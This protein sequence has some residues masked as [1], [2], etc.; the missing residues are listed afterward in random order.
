MSYNTAMFRCSPLRVPPPSR[1]SSGRQPFMNLQ[2]Q[3]RVSSGIVETTPL[4]NNSY[5]WMHPRGAPATGDA[6]VR[7]DHHTPRLQ[8]NGLP[9]DV[10]WYGSGSAWISPPEYSQQ[11]SAHNDSVAS[12]HQVSQG[13][14]HIPPGVSSSSYSQEIDIA[15]STKPHSGTPMDLSTGRGQ[16]ASFGPINNAAGNVTIMSSSSRGGSIAGES[17][18]SY[19]QD[20]MISKPHMIG[21]LTNPGYKNILDESGDKNEV[22]S[23]QQVYSSPPQGVVISRPYPMGE[24]TPI[25]FSVG[26]LVES[27][28]AG[29]KKAS[30]VG[31][32]STTKPRT[33]TTSK[34][35][36]A[37]KLERKKALARVSSA[38]LRERIVM[39]QNMPE[40][41]RTEQ[42]KLELQAFQDRK[43]KKNRRSKERRAEESA[44]VERILAIPEE[45]RS[46][47]EK[48]YVERVTAAKLK[49][50]LQNR[51][52]RERLKQA[53]AAQDKAEMRRILAKPEVEWTKSEKNFLTK[54]KDTVQQT[55]IEELEVQTPVA[56]V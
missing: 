51:Q 21:D 5:C 15:M 16:S 9:M 30:K 24:A 11:V 43:G 19:T 50:N 13:D 12:R 2:Q 49:K 27:P 29:L 39:I 53:K 26:T 41:D 33:M 54:A 22:S 1:Y 47:E 44:E 52:R 14:N 45:E 40:E 7:Q 56:S 3:P 32:V 18:S 48:G 37:E 46:Q 4:M 35:L 38:K 42:Q 23:G 34:K 6:P 8:D 55:S 31:V 10:Q 36:S 28:N 17:P 20:F 25:S